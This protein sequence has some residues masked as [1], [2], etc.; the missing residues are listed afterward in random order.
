MVVVIPVIKSAP[1]PT[2][3]DTERNHEGVKQEEA[4]NRAHD[5]IRNHSCRKFY[6]KNGAWM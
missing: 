4:E 5:A 3:H 2:N 1:K 6:G